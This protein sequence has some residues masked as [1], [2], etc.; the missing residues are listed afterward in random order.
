MER[1][2]DVFYRNAIDQPLP[3]VGVH[4]ASI[5]PQRLGIILVDSKS[6]AVLDQRLPLSRS[7]QVARPTKWTWSPPSSIKLWQ[8][9]GCPLR[10]A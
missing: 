1:G 4:L 8:C 7:G 5:Q 3:S 10:D 2:Q 9:T 6:V